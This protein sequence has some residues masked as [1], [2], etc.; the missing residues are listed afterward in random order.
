MTTQKRSERCAV[1]AL[2]AVAGLLAAGSCL[3]DSDTG[4]NQQA[5]NA[6]HPATG[7]AIRFDATNLSAARFNVTTVAGDFANQLQTISLEAGS[8]SFCAPTSWDCFAFQVTSTG[9]LAYDASLDPYLEGRGGTKLT[10]RGSAVTIDASALG[11]ARF[12]VNSNAIGGADFATNQVRTLSLLPGNYTLCAPSFWDCIAFQVAGDGTVDYE[13]ALDRFVSGRGSRTFTVRGVRHEID[14]TGIDSTF[15][16]LNG[17]T[18]GGTDFANNQVRAF[19]FLPGN[20]TLCAPSFWDC[21]QF[22]ITPEGLIEY[23]HS[24][25]SVLEGRGCYRLV[26][27]G[28]PLSVDATN[29][30][31]TFFNLNSSTIGGTDYPNQR[32]T[33]SLLPG[34]Y[35][36]C[37]PSFWDCL[38]F[39]LTPAGTLDY[40]PS[41]DAFFQGRGTRALTV[42]GAQITIDATNL[43]ATFFNL[44]SSTIGGTDYPNQPRTFSLLPGS[45]TFCS[46]SF[47]DCQ[48]F[49]VTTAGTLDYDHALDS[50]FQGRGTHTLTV[51]GARIT[52]D[53]TAVAATSFNINSNTIGGTDYPNQV[54]TFSLVP[55]A[56]TLCAPA[57]TR[58]LQ[59]QVTT[60]GALDYAAALDA[61]VSGRGGQ[62]LTV[63]AIP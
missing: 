40:D 63:T 23:D 53:T 52:I 61:G 33:F 54:R 31:A 8:Y 58:C 2:V 50:V 30:S 42:R 16:N 28:I 35:T 36:F 3:Y 43:N 6:T 20:Y 34:S 1:A 19:N 5:G 18:I 15:F 48:V 26:L 4:E 51:R 7:F 11:A 41:L 55:G 9:V 14:A 12:S 10:V 44:N 17:N 46:P 59:F 29:L 49:Q 57:F 56:Y 13:H 24:L 27:H 62:R 21:I 32:R 25:D 37:S 39:T 60:A 45:Y 47:W 22:Q 38:A